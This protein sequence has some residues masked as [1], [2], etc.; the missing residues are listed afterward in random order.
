M[1][2]CGVCA[3]E[4]VPTRHS[5]G[6]YCSQNCYQSLPKPITDWKVRFWQYVRKSKGCWKWTGALK[7]PG[8]NRYGM[9][10]IPTGSAKK[11]KNTGAHR[12]SWELHFGPIPSGQLVCHRC[13]NPSCVRPGHL[14]L[15]TNFENMRD[16]S[17][18]GRNHVPDNRGERHGMSKLT[19]KTVAAIR[20]D[21][22][23]KTR[24]NVHALCAKYG[25]AVSTIYGIIDGNRWKHIQ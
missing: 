6:K 10:A 11:H 18:K 19:A 20:R 17:T 4:F 9:L 13:D 2:K 15:G 21:Y 25:V 1:S 5:S 22:R 23:P 12:L 16:A 8:R 7:G 24:G 3:I 14:F